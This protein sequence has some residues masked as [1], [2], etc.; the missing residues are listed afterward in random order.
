VNGQIE[1]MLSNSLK[2]AKRIKPKTANKK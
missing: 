2:E 1:W